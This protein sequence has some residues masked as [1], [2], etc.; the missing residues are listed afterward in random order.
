[1]RAARTTI[2]RKLHKTSP[3]AFKYVLN[4]FQY[5]ENHFVRPISVSI[6]YKS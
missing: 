1:M 5:I 6:L 3:Y 2:N 4:I